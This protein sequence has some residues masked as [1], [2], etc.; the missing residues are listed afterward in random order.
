MARPRPAQPVKLMVGLL[1][2]DLD[3][4]RRA[5]QL[6][7]HDYGPVDLASDV[8]PFDET[9]YYEAEMGPKLRRCFLSFERLIRPDQLAEIKR[10]TNELEQRIADDCLQPDCPRPVNLDPGYLDLARLVLATT[11]DRSHRIYLNLGI[12]AEVTLHYSE[13]AWQ[14]WPWTYPDY[15]KPEYHAFFERVRECYRVQRSQLAALLEPPG[16]KP[17]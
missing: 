16:E 6:L 15:R 9:S 17:A 13:G 8:W 5:R 4:F 12:Y 3:L 14:P 10:Q 2:G 1:S 11:K 7:A